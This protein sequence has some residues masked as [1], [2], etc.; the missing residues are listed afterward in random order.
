[1]MRLNIK[2]ITFLFTFLVYCTLLFSFRY[3][4]AKTIIT[5]RD[6]IDRVFDAIS[7]VK[8]MRYKLHCNERI[9]GRMRYFESKVKLQTSPRKLY[10]S[11]KGPE[12]LWIQDANNGDALVNPSSFPYMN[13]NLDPYGSLMRKDQHHTIYEMG[14]QYLGDILKDATKK[15]GDKFDKYFTVVG[16]DVYNGRPC[17]KLSILFPEF[18]WNSYTVKKGEDLTSIA[19]KLKVTEREFYEVEDPQDRKAPNV[20]F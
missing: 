15:A 9:K 1:M 4:Q 14:F 2:H 3:R 5:S 11:L 17:Y 16:E 6:L 8:T 7:N 12:V 10:L 19:R 20:K 18:A 13:L